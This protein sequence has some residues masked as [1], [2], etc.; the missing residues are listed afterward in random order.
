MSDSLRRKSV[1]CL[2]SEGG[3]TLI[4]A[5]V[6][7]GLIGIL[8]LGSLSISGNM[9]NASVTSEDSQ[10]VTALNYEIN[11]SLYNQPV[12]TSKLAGTISQ[13]G[14]EFS[15]GP[16]IGAG[17]KYGK[18]AIGSLKLTNIVQ[19]GPSSDPIYHADV[20]L[21]GEKR[22][23]GLGG[24]AFTVRSGVYYR[25]SGST[26]TSCVGVGLT[27]ATCA[28]LGGEWTAGSCN[29]CAALGGTLR[30]DGSCGL[31][32]PYAWDLSSW[33]ACTPGGTQ[34][35]TATCMDYATRSPASS[36][37]K[38]IQPAPEET[39]SCTT[40]PSSPSSPSVPTAPAPSGP[41]PYD[42]YS[43]C[44]AGWATQCTQYG[45]SGVPTCDPSEVAAQCAAMC[46]L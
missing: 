20:V 24:Q 19:V 5:L 11:A 33:S 7:V 2:D 17:K 1:V 30:G 15:L 21:T 27:S 9:L 42:C 44:Y 35:R 23:M 6:G 29:F 3:F 43:T 4:E 25:T 28:T 18:I 10:E 46:G 26:I 39:Q 32:S 36:S 13:E 34:T 37:S 45:G 14:V 8:A 31:P 38:C 16:A 40:A 12:C 22:A 41:S